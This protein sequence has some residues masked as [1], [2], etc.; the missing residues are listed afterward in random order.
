MQQIKFY[1][2]ILTAT[3]V[4]NNILNAYTQSSFMDVDG[5]KWYDD[6]NKFAE[7]QK[8]LFNHYNKDKITI[9]VVIG[10]IS[11]LSPMSSWSRNKKLVEKFLINETFGVCNF[12]N[13]GYLSLGINKA[14]KIF[15]NRKTITKN[16]IDVVLNGDKIKAFFDNILYP[17]SSN[18]VT[19]DRHALSIALG[20]KL[21]GEMYKLHVPTN[22]H[23][24]FFQLCYKL[25]GKQSNISGLKIQSKTWAALRIDNKKTLLKSKNLL[26]LKK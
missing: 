13:L 5:L 21:T 9:G 4:K 14:K 11:S 8:I 23:N 17:K 1:G 2:E 10:I 7:E 12:E 6:A 18:L 26:K 24:K 3:K 16:E 25:A 22:N 15:D 19:I 20:F